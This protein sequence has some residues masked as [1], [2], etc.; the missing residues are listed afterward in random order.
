VFHGPWIRDKIW[1][2]TYAHTVTYS[3]VPGSEVRL[4]FQGASLTYVYTRAANR[5]MADIAIDGA[6]KSTLD[7]YSPQAEWQSRTTF[8]LGA[9]R[10]LAV[11]TILPDKNPKSSDRFID[12]DAFEVQ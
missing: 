2:Q 9:G 5:G 3:S 10:H 7:L 11:I 8:E 4:A 6:R 12:V 1:P